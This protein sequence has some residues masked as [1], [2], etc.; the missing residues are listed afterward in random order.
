MDQLRSLEAP[1]FIAGV[2]PLMRPFL[3]ARGRR[4][5]RRTTALISALEMLRTRAAQD[6]DWINA[7]LNG[8]QMPLVRTL[9]AFRNTS[10]ASD[11]SHGCLH[12]AY[13]SRKNKHFHCPMPA[14]L[15][16]RTG[17]N[18]WQPKHMTLWESLCLLLAA[19][20]G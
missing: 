9:R 20:F 5:Q 4:L 1:P 6:M 17:A 13:R 19:K 7:L 15:I 14:E 10:L 12:F 2:V 8:K 18:Q 11:H 16:L 3:S